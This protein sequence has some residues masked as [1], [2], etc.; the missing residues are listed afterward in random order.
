MNVTLFESIVPFPDDVRFVTSGF[1]VLP[2]GVSRM[3]IF[4]VANDDDSVEN[5]EIGIVT[6]VAM[7]P[8]DMVVGSTELLIID[9]DGNY[10]AV[11]L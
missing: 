1:I 8:N 9:N 2:V 11:H 3:C 10:L 5:N 4:I 6:L 7:N